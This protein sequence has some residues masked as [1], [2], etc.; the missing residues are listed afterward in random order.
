MDA[1]FTESIK[2][3]VAIDNQIKKHNERLRELRSQRGDIQESIMEYVDTNSLS[4]TT[5]RISDGKLK[6]AQS[7]QTAPLTLRYVEACLH[8]CIQDE[9]D[10]KAIMQYIKKSRESKV[11][12][13]I[14]R[15]Y[16]EQSK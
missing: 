5:I 10:V 16:S 1:D 14:K 4:N 13:D 2:Q 3:W 9:S 6:F 12:P 8:K 7:R 11:Y 15:S